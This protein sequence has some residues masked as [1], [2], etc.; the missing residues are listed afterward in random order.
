[1][2]APPSAPT[3]SDQLWYHIF[4]ITPFLGSPSWTTYSYVDSLTLASRSGRANPPKVRTQW[5]GG[6]AGIQASSV[7]CQ[8]PVSAHHCLRGKC[9]FYCFNSFPLTSLLLSQNASLTLT[10]FSKITFY[11]F[12]LPFFSRNTFYG[13]SW[14]KHFL[15]FKYRMPICTLCCRIILTPVFPFPF[16][17]VANE[18]SVVTQLIH[19]FY[20]LQ[21]SVF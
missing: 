10:L 18:L 9:P 17:K 21:S 4:L 19:Q 11:L 12:I 13:T 6:S 3:T 5:V 15:Q 7:W 14:S 20:L 8:R 2:P 16:I 1:M